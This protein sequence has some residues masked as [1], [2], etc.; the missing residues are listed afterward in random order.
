MKISR[1]YLA[2]LILICIGDSV[3]VAATE[4]GMRSGGAEV[5]IN[6]C[7]EPRQ[8]ITALQLVRKDTKSLEV[9]FFD[10]AGLDLFRRGVLF[11]LRSTGR[12]NELTLKVGNQDCARVNPELLPAGL[13]KCEYDVHGA[14]SV[15]A[16]SI[17]RILDE[18]QL[19]GLLEGQVVLADLLSPAQ[20]RYLRENAAVWP[21]PPGL[22]RLGPAHI[23]TYRRKGKPFDV[24]LWQLPSGR[25]YLEISRKCRLEDAPRVQA[26]LEGMLVSKSLKLCPDQGPQAGGRFKDLLAR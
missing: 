5:Q 19:R 7:S 12:K 11:R 8:V 6:I 10:T 9:W 3:A 14:H 21:L 2:L 20:V 26:E 24:E 22:M 17:S 16:V 18:T 25:R 13:A 4:D 23:E 1:Y 15:A